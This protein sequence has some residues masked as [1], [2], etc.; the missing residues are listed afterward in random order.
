M[1]RP[2]DPRRDEDFRLWKES[3]GARLLKDIAD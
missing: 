1:V 3:D 2:R